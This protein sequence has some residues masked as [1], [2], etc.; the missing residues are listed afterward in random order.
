MART[1]GARPIHPPPQTPEIRPDMQAAKEKAGVAEADMKFAT[2][3]TFKLD[4]IKTE[5]ISRANAVY[6]PACGLDVRSLRVL[7]I[8]CDAPGVTA[9]VVK[10]QTLIEKT[11]LSKL[12][13]DLIERKLVRRTI[14]PGD[15]R[16]FQLWP[17]A[18][19]KR[20]RATSDEI[21]RTLEAQMLSVLDADEH[22]AL[23]RIVNKLVE[24]FRSSALGDEAK[25]SE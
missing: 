23:D 17:T 2:Y 5:M 19:G 13:A 14:H 18:A 9:T 25:P 10:E 8:I 7:R 3:L 16:H 15:A 24:S 4:L 12:M 22:A 6:K 1:H 20:T 11:L 21:G